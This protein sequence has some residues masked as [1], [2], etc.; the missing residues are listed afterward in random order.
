MALESRSQIRANVFS[1]PVPAL[2]LHEK[3]FFKFLGCQL[4]VPLSCQ[5]LR[6]NYLLYFDV[7]FVTNQLQ[8][9]GSKLNIPNLLQQLLRQMAILFTSSLSL[10]QRL[11]WMVTTKVSR[12][13]E[14]F[15]FDHL[16]ASLDWPPILP[17]EDLT[18]E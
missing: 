4:I 17:R 5:N 11:S 15:T 3:S 13:R 8:I 9:K 10:Q 6:L 2:V 12:R 14:L 16:E 7:A 1:W 18:K